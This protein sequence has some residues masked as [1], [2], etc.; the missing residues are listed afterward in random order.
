MPIAKIFKCGNSQALRL[1]KEFQFHSKEI[2]IFR[3]GG[4]VILREKPGNLKRA[5][6]LLASMPN[7]F[8]SQERKDSIPQKR[9]SFIFVPLFSTCSTLNL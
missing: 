8:F 6:K 2:E 3:R 1:P 4:D 5:F 9:D 7:D